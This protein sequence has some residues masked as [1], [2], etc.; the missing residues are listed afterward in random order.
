MSKG[1][2]PWVVVLLGAGILIALLDYF[3][4]DDRGWLLWQTA[5]LDELQQKENIWLSDYR[6]VI[7]GK[8]LAWPVD[9]QASGL[10]WNPR[11]NTLFT[12]AGRS[13]KLVE[14][15][16]EGKV[17][18][19]VELQGFADLEGIA[20]LN[21]GRFAVIDERN[22]SL[23]VFELTDDTAHIAAKDWPTINLGASRA[24][25]KG[26][27]GIVWDEVHRRFLLAKER[28]PLGL[29]ALPLAAGSAVAE[30]TEQDL[31]ALPSEHIFALDFSGLALD[32][33]TGHLL[34]LSDESRMLL[35]LDEEGQPV[36]FMSFIMGFNGLTA[37]INQA[38]GVAIDAEGTIYIMSE[39]NLFYVFTNQ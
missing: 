17:L 20:V 31:I 7:Q 3:H 25:N 5:D 8:P 9:E 29:Y 4:W 22:A 32:P 26:F 33:R 19:A 12:V 27:E 1:L 16:L 23:T 2:K 39:P 6:V 24:H 37:N 36:S 28:D 14:L 21:D 34:V 18:R 35:E 15:S 38:E 13:A 11:T 10:S 30:M